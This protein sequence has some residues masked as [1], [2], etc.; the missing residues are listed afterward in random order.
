MFPSD[1]TWLARLLGGAIVL[2]GTIVLILAL[3]RDRSRGRPRC[4]KCWY[5]VTGL[6]GCPECGWSEQQGGH[7]FRTRRHYRWAAL[8]TLL[9]VVGVVLL[10]IPPRSQAARVAAARARILATIAQLKQLKAKVAQAEAA[11]QPLTAAEQQKL[12]D[13]IAPLSQQPSSF[14]SMIQAEILKEAKP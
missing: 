12:L 3:F 10:T 8:A 7:A 11:G 14:R 13:N 9:M 5:D 4:P 1:L 6:T 2:S